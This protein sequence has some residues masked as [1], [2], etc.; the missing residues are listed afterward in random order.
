MG[1]LARA[2]RKDDATEWNKDSGSRLRQREGAT[3]VK[4][5]VQAQRVK[6][7]ETV[8]GR[9]SEAERDRNRDEDQQS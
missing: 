5:S 4:E 3:R 6:L 1:T 7:E 2:C 8:Q 9:A